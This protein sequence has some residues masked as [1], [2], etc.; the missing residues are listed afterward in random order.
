ML[1]YFRVCVCKY[2]ATINKMIVFFTG[3]F[4]VSVI[5][6]YIRVPKLLDKAETVITRKP[7][8]HHWIL[9]SYFYTCHARY[10]SVS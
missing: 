3:Y 4:C 9:H 7:E 2:M 8:M 6:Q 1:I 10:K 5:H